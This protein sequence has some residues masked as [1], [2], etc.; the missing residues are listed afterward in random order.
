MK[1]HLKAK[2]GSCPV[3]SESLLAENRHEFE[4][5]LAFCQQSEQTFWEFEKQ[6]FAIMKKLG[7]LLVSLFLR[8]RH[9][10]LDLQP[11]LKA[12]A[13]YRRGDDQARR[14]VKTAYGKVF[15]WRAQ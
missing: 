2:V 11:F 12:E 5:A 7:C 1:I 14:S 8:K 13:G 10:R 9:E 4:M 15:F 6:L 3:T